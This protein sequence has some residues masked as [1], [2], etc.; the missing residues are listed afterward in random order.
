VKSTG[1]QTVERLVLVCGWRRRMRFD[2]SSGGEC[3]RGEN[4]KRRGL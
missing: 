2:I 1:R 3:V 4:G